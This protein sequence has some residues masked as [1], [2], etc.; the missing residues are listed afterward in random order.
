MGERTI[1]DLRQMQALP[2]SVKVRMTQRRIRE[3]VDEF[4]KDGVYVSFSGGK[5]STVLLHIV[6]EMYPD[7]PAV[8]CDTGLE[9]PEIREFVKTFDNVGWLKPKMTFR[10]VIGKYG[11]PF[12][13]KAVSGIVGGGQ[14]AM[15]MLRSE[16][17]DIT[18]RAEVV[19][20][21]ARRLKKE[22]GEWRRL[23]Q[24][25]G[26]VTKGNII[27][28]DI[29]E[30]ENGFYS[31]IPKKYKFLM[32]A[33]FR[34]SDK[35]CREMKKNIVHRY[36]KETG[37]TQMTAMMAEEGNLRRQQW[38]RAGCNAFENKSP[39]SN[40]MAFWTEQDVLHYI[41]DHGIKIAEV[42]GDI[43]EKEELPGQVNWSDYAG[44]DIGGTELKTTGCKRT[45]CMFCG[46]GCH[47]EKPGEGRF[48]LMK[49]THPKQYAYIMKPWDE[50]GLGYK[51]VIDWINEHGNL[52]I[53]Y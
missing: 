18:D 21:C 10:Q 24:C 35:C 7:I 8:F 51:D 9:Y 26:A 39:I 13:S 2:L 31:D 33:P 34:V 5:D 1:N 46:Y 20:Q 49:K 47:L 6:R 45:G 42:Y 30:K 32:S 28:E 43:V 15:E 29:S 22:P 16:G 14:S 17:I 40:P 4:G 48:E 53:R 52:N 3:W 44:F 38:L 37:R 50:G 23:A 19:R 36:M 27:K 11:Y 25:I 41:K 12:I